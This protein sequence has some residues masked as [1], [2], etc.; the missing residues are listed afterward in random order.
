M[1]PPHDEVRILGKQWSLV[2]KANLVDEDNNPAFGLCETWEQRIRYTT[3][4]TPSQLRDTVWHELL[5]AIEETMGL[6]LSESQVHAL[7]AGQLAVFADNPWLAEFMFERYRQ[8]GRN[9]RIR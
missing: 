1:K 6:G 3:E 2:G 5:H 8:G 7:A 4:T 9:E